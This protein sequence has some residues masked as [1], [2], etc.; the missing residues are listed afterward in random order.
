MH[1]RIYI[2]TPSIYINILIWK[3]FRE[4]SKYMS[5]VHCGYFYKNSSDDVKKN[6]CGFAVAWTKRITA[7][8]YIVAWVDKMQYK[9]IQ[10]NK[11]YG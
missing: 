1:R 9:Y 7:T 10:I 11:T 6:S 4:F 2:Q 3:L 8:R 5:A